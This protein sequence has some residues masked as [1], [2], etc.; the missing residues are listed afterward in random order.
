LAGT[1]RAPTWWDIARI[2]LVLGRERQRDIARSRL[3][4]REVVVAPKR[5]L[6]VNP[7]VF[8]II[9]Q[10]DGTYDVEASDGG[11]SSFLV[12]FRT[13][14]EAEAWITNLKGM[15]N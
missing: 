6:E 11:A 4:A 15:T 1:S 14:V 9:P 2:G 10:V 7:V 12:S 13:R 3:T 5:R 8:T